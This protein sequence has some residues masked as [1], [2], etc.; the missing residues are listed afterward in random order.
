[1]SWKTAWGGVRPYRFGIVVGVVAIMLGAWYGPTLV[2]G[3]RVP[4]VAI[5]RRDLV[6]TVVA[7]G[8][9]E[10][11]HRVDIGTQITGVVARVPV[12]EGQTV[13]AVRR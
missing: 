5:E 11:P 8:H 3:P 12:A 1:M 9:V 6:Q 2:L 4:V 10:A 13:S 7:S